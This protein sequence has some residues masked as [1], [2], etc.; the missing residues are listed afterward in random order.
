MDPEK[1]RMQLQE[2]PFFPGQ[3]LR[4]PSI[5]NHRQPLRIIELLVHQFFKATIDT[6]ALI[7]GWLP[8]FAKTGLQIFI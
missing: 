6:D 7:M 2:H 1:A 5:G 3:M 8:G 4:G